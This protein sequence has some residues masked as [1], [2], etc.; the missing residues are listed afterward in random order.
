MTFG[1]TPDSNNKDILAVT[2]GTGSASGVGVQLLDK[3]EKST[4]FIYGLCITTLTP[5]TTTNDLQFGAR[6]IRPE[7]RCLPDWRMPR[8][9]SLSFT[10]NKADITTP[11][12]NICAITVSLCE[13]IFWPPLF[14]YC[15]RC[16]CGYYHWRHARSLP[17][18]KRILYWDHQRTI[19]IIWCS[20]GS[21]RKITHVK[22]PF[23]ITPPL[24]R[25]DAKQENVLRIIRTGG[26][27]PADRESLFWLNIKSIPSSARNER[28]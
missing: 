15:L 24:F 20:H 27:L 8:L 10:T 9:P 23:L 18:S 1:R 17:E 4:E 13:N 14:I 26:N 28:R 12:A 16:P 22:A 2:S 6:Y 21:K 5:G 7:E 3:T 19:S 25:L 11:V